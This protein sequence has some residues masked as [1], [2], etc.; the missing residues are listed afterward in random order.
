MATNLPTIPVLD[1]A[2][3]SDDTKRPEF[4]ALLRYALIDV[5]FLYLKNHSVP[6]ELIDRVCEYVPRLFNIPQEEKDKLLMINSP[7]FMGFSRLRTELTGGF[8]DHREQFDFGT[9]YETRWKPGITPDHWGLWG[10]SQ[11][12]EEDLIPGF[13]E[14]F[15]TY[16]TAVH[17]ETIQLMSLFAEA[18]QLP[19]DAFAKFHEPLDKMQSRAKEW[20]SLLNRSFR[21]YT[22]LVFVDLQI[23]KYPPTQE[24]SQQ[25]FMGNGPHYDAGLVTFV[26]QLPS[27]HPALQMQLG[28]EWIDIPPIPGTFTVNLGQS[29]EYITQGAVRAT[30]HHV[31]SSPIGSD[32]RY[33]LPFFQGC[34]LEVCLADEVLDIPPEILKLRDQRK[35]PI[36]TDPVRDKELYSHPSGYV[37]FLRG[38]KSHPDISER[39]YPTLFK[40]YFPDGKP[41]QLNIA[42]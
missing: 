34:R 23:I 5:G 40:E 6:Q 8:I 13:R 3:L 29:L 2:V 28:D 36:K 27:P 37:V 21:T 18:L 9:T 11:W 35:Y 14:T 25:G 32:A 24:G 38:I 33:A 7:H 4:I 16:L 30:Y 39:H 19:S 15:E 20:S 17:N 41:K 12:P 42:Y 1:L 22:S 31:V 26:L 10:P